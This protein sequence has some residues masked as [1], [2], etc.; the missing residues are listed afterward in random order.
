LARRWLSD[1]LVITFAAALSE[2]SH[3]RDNVVA[4]RS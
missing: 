4:W 3:Q 2:L 1:V